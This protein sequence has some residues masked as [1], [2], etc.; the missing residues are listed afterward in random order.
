MPRE[1]NRVL[2]ALLTGYGYTHQQLADEVNRTA[3]IR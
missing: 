3:E 2:E 1:R